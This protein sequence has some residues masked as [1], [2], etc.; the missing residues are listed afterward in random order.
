MV[1]LFNHSDVPFEGHA[2]DRIAQMVVE[3]VSL[4]APVEVD[5]LD[6]SERG[7]AGFGSTGR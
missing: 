5:E 3:R 1:I 4:C 7:E 6:E 2:G